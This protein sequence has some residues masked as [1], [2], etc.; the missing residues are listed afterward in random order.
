LYLMKIG[1]NIMLKAILT[2]DNKRNNMIIV[3]ISTDFLSS[4]EADRSIT[5]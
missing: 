4:I 2:F 3:L 5:C 1:Y